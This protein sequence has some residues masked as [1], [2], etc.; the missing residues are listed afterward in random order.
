[1]SSK[2]FHKRSKD[3]HRHNPPAIASIS[4]YHSLQ[5][6]MPVTIEETFNI[7]SMSSHLKGFEEMFGDFQD[8]NNFNKLNSSGNL[9]N[10]YEYPSQ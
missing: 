5:P 10:K 4:T 6:T 8:D 1:M 3:S 9:T 2:K 7:W